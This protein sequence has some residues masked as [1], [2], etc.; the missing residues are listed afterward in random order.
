VGLRPNYSA[1]K[2]GIS[3]SE[4]WLLDD[5]ALANAAGQKTILVMHTV[6]SIDDELEQRIQAAANER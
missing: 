1:S 4:A 2:I 3:N 6:T 5:I